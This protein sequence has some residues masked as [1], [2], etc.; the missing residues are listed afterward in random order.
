M[1]A[2]VE[3][4]RKPRKRS[5]IERAIRAGACGKFRRGFDWKGQNMRVG[6]RESDIPQ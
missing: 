5:A 3:D 2:A 6:G 1:L 4:F